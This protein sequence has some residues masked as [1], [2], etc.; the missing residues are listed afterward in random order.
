MFCLFQK[1]V[2]PDSSVQSDLWPSLDKP[3]DELKRRA[4]DMSLDLVTLNDGISGPADV[5]WKQ[6]LD[7]NTRL[8]GI[9]ASR[10][11]A[12]VKEFN[13]KKKYHGKDTLY[14]LWCQIREQFEMRNTPERQYL[15]YLF[16]A[17]SAFPH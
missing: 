10:M 11:H 3:M 2:L 16:I 8:R 14:H 17:K 5:I 4:R 7:L 9:R 12:H 6:F 13:W 15:I 1:H